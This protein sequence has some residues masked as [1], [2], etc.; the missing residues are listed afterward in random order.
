MLSRIYFIRTNAISKPIS[1]NDCAYRIERELFCFSGRTYDT[2]VAFSIVIEAS[3]YVYAIKRS[4]FH[5]FHPFRDLKKKKIPD[6]F[7]STFAL[8]SVRDINRAIV[9]FIIL[10]HPHRSL[11][12]AYFRARFYATQFF[13]STHR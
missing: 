8:T 12:A 6:T 13:I 7:T 1:G 11:L 4:I 9:F 3:L 2:P 10:V 5:A